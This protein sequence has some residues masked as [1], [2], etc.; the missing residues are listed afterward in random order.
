MFATVC[1]CNVFLKFITKGLVP[2]LGLFGGTGEQ[3]CVP[4]ERYYSHWTPAFEGYDRIPPF[5]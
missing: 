1:I 4:S 3:K 2:V 5:L